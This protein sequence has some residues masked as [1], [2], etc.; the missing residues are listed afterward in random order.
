MLNGQLVTRDG[1]NLLIRHG[2]PAALNAMLVEAG[3]RVASITEQRR[4]LEQVVLEVTGAG[5]DRVDA[6]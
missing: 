3:L 6:S 5:S 1:E 2:D 4:T